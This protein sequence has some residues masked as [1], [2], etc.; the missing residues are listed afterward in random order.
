MTGR[1]SAQVRDFA[2]E[3]IRLEIRGFEFFNQAAGMTH[4]A[5]GQKMFRHL[6]QQEIHHLEA[7]RKLF[8]ESVSAEE[9][10]KTVREEEAAGRSA[11]IEDLVAR[12]KRAEGKGEIEAIRIGMELEL[13]AIEFFKGCAAAGDDPAAKDIFVTIADEERYHYDLLQAQYD[14]VTGTG[15]W[16]DSAEFQMDGKY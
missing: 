1:P 3:A 8:A 14:S 15:Y 12:M 16:L 10:K 9:W 6:A 13:K 11:V 7:F 2:R 4:N 5:L